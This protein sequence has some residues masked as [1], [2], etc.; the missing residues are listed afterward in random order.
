MHRVVKATE[1]WMNESGHGEFVSVI[2]PADD[3]RDGL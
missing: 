2:V 1:A 3:D